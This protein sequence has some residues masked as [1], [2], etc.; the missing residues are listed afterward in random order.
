V[1]ANLALVRS[2]YTALERG[3]FDRADWADPH[4]EYVLAD[5]PS[6][7]T[8]HGLA[9]LRDAMRLLLNAWEDVRIHVDDLRKLDGERVLVLLHSNS[10]RG[11]ASGIEMA[12]IFHSAWR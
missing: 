1:S 2:I 7:G 8:F 5:G 11:K 12:T 6:P 10:G 3:A 4:I 9:G